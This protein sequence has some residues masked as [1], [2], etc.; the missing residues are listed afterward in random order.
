MLTLQNKAQ[1]YG[2]K[3][4]WETMGQRRM[5]PAI[6]RTNRAI[7]FEAAPLLYTDMTIGTQTCDV[8]CFSESPNV[9][10]IIPGQ[11]I[12]RLWRHN[13]LHGTGQPNARGVQVYASDE[14]NGD[15]EP[16]IFARFQRLFFDAWINFDDYNVEPPLTI[17]RSGRFAEDDEI[18]LGATMRQ[19][20]M[21]R[22][23]VSLLSNSP[24]IDHLYVL[25]SSD[26]PPGYDWGPEPSTEEEEALQDKE[27]SA[28]MEAIDYRAIEIF[29]D[30]NMLAPLETLDNVKS[31]GVT[32]DNESKL[33]SH[34]AKIIRDL[35]DKIEG[36][37]QLSQAAKRSSNQSFQLAP[38][39]SS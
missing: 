13:P 17:D 35:R 31:F 14:M 1:G 19:S 25:L 20:N 5:Y 39:G 23:L 27:D 4:E 28:L 29:I 26:L 8:L 30:S 15:M 10:G 2:G 21:I 6:L 9:H 16:H 32:V 36:N 18:R 37:W 11:G 12:P 3:L 22:T 38:I 7:Y 34:H 33:Q 24:S